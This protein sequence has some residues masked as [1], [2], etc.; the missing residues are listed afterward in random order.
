MASAPNEKLIST[1]YWECIT[2]FQLL[3]DY[4]NKN[5]EVPEKLLGAVGQ[6]RVWA[7]NLAAHRRGSIS[8]DY[9]L[10]EASRFSKHVK[11]LLKDL[12]DVVRERVS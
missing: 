2:S 5:G 9:K 7:E 1:H 12:N 4:L 10:R 8:L 6:L 11:D 3:F